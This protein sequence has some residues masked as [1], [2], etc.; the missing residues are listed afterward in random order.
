[1][2]NA[3][4]D[5]PAAAREIIERFDL[6][7][8]PEGGW[9]RQTFR[10]EVGDASD[11]SSAAAP[12]AA[13]STA[14][15]FLLARG[16]RSHWHRVLHA[17]EVWHHYAGAPIRL[18]LSTDGVAVEEHLLGMDVAAGELPQVVVPVGVWQ[19]A[20]S[21]GEWTLVGCTVAPGFEFDPFELAPPGWEPG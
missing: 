18:R 13:H 14:I 6:E 20:E 11:G 7:P 1:M 15:Y 12:G 17:A 16:E 5:L 10:D 3:P 21:L 9:Y 4:A 8:H 19:S 2:S